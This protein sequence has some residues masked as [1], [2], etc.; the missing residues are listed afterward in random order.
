MLWL[1][2]RSQSHWCLL[3]ESW[4][5]TLAGV[6]AELWMLSRSKAHTWHAGPAPS[7]MQVGRPVQQHPHSACCHPQLYRFP[8]FHG[9][10]LLQPLGPLCPASGGSSGLCGQ[11]SMG[12][13]GMLTPTPT[14]AV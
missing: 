6:L 3:W 8:C 4:A 9:P 1:D 2:P 11:H 10:D 12:T 14:H 13:C 7:S 5:Q